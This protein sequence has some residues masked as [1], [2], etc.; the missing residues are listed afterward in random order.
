MKTELIE[1]ETI[2]NRLTG[3]NTNYSLRN[4]LFN[5]YW[6]YNGIGPQAVK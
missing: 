5:K 4:K 3:Q 6:V 1:V 2:G